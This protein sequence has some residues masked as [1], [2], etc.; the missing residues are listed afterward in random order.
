M[1]KK[2]FISTVLFFSVSCSSNLNREIIRLDPTNEKY[3]TP[4]CREI[5]KTILDQKSDPSESVARGALSTY[6]LGAISLPA[7]GFLEIKSEEYKKSLI[8]ELKRNCY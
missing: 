1:F 8:A 7:L 5:R 4:G 3:H 6:F 2:L